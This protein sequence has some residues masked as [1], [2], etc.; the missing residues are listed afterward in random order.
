M[1]SQ[2]HVMVDIETLDVTPSAV[3]LSIGACMM[4]PYGEKFY[5]ELARDTQ[6]LRTASKSTQEWWDQQG[7]MPHGT[8]HIET[9]LLQFSAWLASLGGE[10]IIWCKGTDFDISILTHAYRWLRLDV[11]WKYNNVRDCRTVF[12]L[13][14]FKPEKANHNALT[15]AIV[16]TK[17]LMYCLNQLGLKLS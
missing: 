5:I 6:W 13:A 11:P 9:A 14:G 4:D 15:D 2:N 1:I 7:N 17:D 10:P 12:K 3:I 16:Q 8:M